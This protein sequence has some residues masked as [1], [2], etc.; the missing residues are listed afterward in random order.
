MP[1]IEIVAINSTGLNLKQEDF[2]VAI[3]EENKLLG[4]RGLFNK[5]F[6]GQSGV[7]VHIG[8]PECKNRN[9]GFFGG[10]I[11]DWDFEPSEILIPEFDPNDQ[12][13]N[14]GANQQFRFKFLDQYK[15]EIDKLLKIALDSS[16]IKKVY[17]MTD[18]QFG[19][20]IGRKEIIYTS[21]DLWIRHD[22]GGLNLNTMY[23]LYGR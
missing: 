4:H 1:T 17:F 22:N 15:A 14:R 7:I 19:P 20:E 11:I 21:S 10:G 6:K 3:I 12:T 23:E 5:F 13:D 9:N 18:Y 16:T 2:D 8:S